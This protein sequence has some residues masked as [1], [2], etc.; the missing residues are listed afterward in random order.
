MMAGGSQTNAGAFST[1]F[2][3]WNGTTWSELFALNSSPAGGVLAY[4]ARH[5]TM[6]LDGFAYLSWESAT[7]HEVCDSGFDVDGDGLIGCADPDCW[8]SCTPLC[9]PDASCDP[10]APHCGD[11]T[12]GP[13]ESCRLC[14]QDCGTCAPICGDTFCDPGE[15]ITSCPGDCS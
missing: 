6:L 10:A 14:P 3:E 12:C 11:G 8:G 7:P 13:I 4:D 9:P 1:D 2:W 15:T 5:S